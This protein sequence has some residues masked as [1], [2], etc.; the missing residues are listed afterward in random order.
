MFIWSGLGLL[1]PVIAGAS[2]ILVQLITGALFGD[3]DYYSA[4]RWPQLMALAL[5]A[6]TIW[7]VGT[8][9]NRRS[10]RVMID[11]KTGQEIEIRGSHGLFFIP[12]VYWAPIVLVVGS[13]A[14]WAA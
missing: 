4:H 3:S 12:F 2:L 9:L 1:V 14:A 6:V 5:A 10:S 11:A 13:W 7:Y 8:Y